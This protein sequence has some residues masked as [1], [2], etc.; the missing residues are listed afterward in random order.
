[1]S[2]LTGDTGSESI[3][4]IFRLVD[5]SDPGFL[6]LALDVDRDG[7]IDLSGVD[8]EVG[9]TA[10]LIGNIDGI[11]DQAREA[12]FR[13]MS[14]NDSYQNIL[15]TLLALVIMFYAIFLM[16]GLAEISGYQATLTFLKI[17]LVWNFA[18]NWALFDNYI[19]DFFED[20]VFQVS[21][22]MSQTFAASPDIDD[23]FAIVD[24][25]LSM[26]FSWQ[27][28]KVVLAL[29]LA[30]WTGWIYSILLFFV[31]L[32]YLHAII[33][34]VKVFILAMIARS[35]LY[36]LAPLFL[37]FALFNQTRTL[38]FGWVEQLINF[39]LQP[40]FVFAFLGMFH[41]VLQGFVIAIVQ[42]PDMVIRYDQ[43]IDS[44]A[45]GFFGINF[46]WWVIEG[47]NPTLKPRVV[48]PGVPI[49]VSLWTVFAI[50]LLTYLLKNMIKWSVDVAGRLS[51]GAVSL[52][53]VR[54]PGAQTF[55]K[56]MKM[57]AT[58]IAQGV[59]MATVGAKGSDGVRRRSVGGGLSQMAKG[60]LSPVLGTGLAGGTQA[61]RGEFVNSF[62]KEAFGRD[63]PQRPQ[64]GNKA[65]GNRNDSGFGSGNKSMRSPIMNMKES[66][67]NDSLKPRQR[68][69]TADVKGA[70]KGGTR[71]AATGAAAGAARGAAE[72]AATGAAKYGAKGAKLGAK[73]K[74]A[75]P[76][77]T[78]ITTV[79]G[80]AV[81]AAVEGTKKA[82]EGAAKG[83]KEGATKGAAKEMEREQIKSDRKRMDEAR[84][85]RDEKN[86]DK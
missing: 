57:Q 52:G 20:L 19:V 75:A 34:A 51:S 1:M 24:G 42:D 82:A 55:R 35:L 6:K 83:A 39:S 12:I 43:I 8:E 71:G 74:W 3:A 47:V 81:G 28:M 67:M 36:A 78:P 9:V 15:H 21:A 30:G 2:N 77:V 16:L 50:L 37:A 13:V 84:K 80:A 68:S 63:A 25:N 7:I 27:Y 54:T 73:T 18:T 69:K 53:D 40:I 33:E 44:G 41:L 79:G 5:D 17:I 49:P 23:T 86:K 59:K 85:K 31:L 72:G 38:F 22:V 65:A 4:D 76:I 66:G 14:D 62:Y 58:G 29:F 32:F 70:L 48:G 64:S 61:G 60:A 46:N 45:L 10:W 56:G 11:L 26:M